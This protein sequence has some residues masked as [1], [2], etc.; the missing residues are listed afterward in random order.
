MDTPDRS[1][2]NT[3]LSQFEDSPVFNYISNL[4]PIEPVKSVHI[5]QTF[6]SLSFSS[7]PSVFTSPHVNCHRES[8]FLRRHNL[9]DAS[10][11]KGSS[12]DINNVYSC[13]KT[14]AD[15]TQPCHESS[16]PQE[17]TNPNISI[18]DTSIE[19]CDEN[20][21]I[22]I[23]V[24]QGLKY[25]LASPGYEPV[26][27]AD[28]ADSL[29]ELPG[30]PGSD[31]S[32][33]PD[34]SE[35]DSIEGEMHLPALCQNEEK[36]EGPNCGVDD[37]IN[38]ASDL[39]MFSPPNMKEAFKDI[40]KQLNPSTKLTNLR[41][42][43]RQSAT[44]DGHQMHIVDTV[45]SGSEH[46]IENHP[47]ESGAA[48]D[49]V[50]RQG[51]HNNVALVAS[52]PIEKVDDK[53]VYVTHRGIRRR[54]LDFE[55]AS[56]Q[57]K[58]LDG[59]SNT[60]SSAEK[61]DEMD[62]SKGKQLLPIKHSGDSRKC[63][64]PGIGLHLNA[65]ASLNDCKN[66]KIE[67]LLSGRQP[68]LPSSSS[69]LQLSASQDH[70]L[71][72]VPTSVEKDMEQSDNEVQ[73]GEDCTQPLVHMP[74]EDCTQ[75]LVHM[76]GEDCTQP[77]VHMPGEDFQQNS[78]K[79]KR[80]RL[81]QDGEGES[82]KRCNCKKSKC[83]KLYCECFAA[84]VYCIEP[85]S[86]RDCF[87]KPIHVDT[88]LQT[89]QQIES[90][91]P[92]A[93][94]PKVIRSSDSVPE[95]GDDPNKTPASA[96]H[97]R[98]CNCKKSSCLKKYCE[99]YQGG[100]GCSISCRCEGCKNTYGRKDGSV[101]SGIEAKPEEETEACEKGVMENASHKTETQ[102]T[103]DHPDHALPTTPLRLSRSLIP[104]PFSSK[105][106]PP[107]SFV[108]TISSS[109]L[110]VSQ[111]LGK[112]SAPRS[113]PKFEMPVQTVPDDDSPVTCIKTS[114][115]NGKRISSPNCDVGSSPTRRGGRKL[116]LQSIPSFPSLTPH[117]LR[118]D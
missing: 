26:I 33:V 81:E 66:I 86:C 40:N 100:V 47:C 21:N 101:H 113:Q 105:G 45:A 95:I 60:N 83:L 67:T 43:L 31:V 59:K 23:E 87:N 106:K 22:S 97:K 50:Q 46:E 12:E 41:T 27:C 49:T 107:R 56:V 11:C 71:S 111:K 34:D 92:L 2:I 37:L 79:K 89:R 63:V 3:P 39:L 35:K 7:P 10:K 112:S 55:M 88:V 90:R 98:G 24:P 30:K 69:S 84:G 102:N 18:R 29:L 17:N 57:R 25:N 52:N 4:S 13:E 1:K 16:E 38:E 117:N 9:L 70:Q 77:L 80:R 75:P 8:R 68:N 96:R 20:P 103:E 48:T 32:Y 65:L 54:C 15:S 118:S 62:V 108:T 6:N 99:C 109:G 114:S 19:P 104:L 78:P 94:A 64:L 72:L 61:S 76:P 85:C 28:E 5:T 42:L 73:P 36:I 74:G 82:C 14:P 53:L 51:K 115:P 91:N 116:I 110:F 58:N 93:F 44:N